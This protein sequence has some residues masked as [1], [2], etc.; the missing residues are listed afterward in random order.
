ML[1]RV[2]TSLAATKGRKS[3]ILVSEGFIYDPNLDEFK[4]R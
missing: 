2:L 4:A 1:E 3:V